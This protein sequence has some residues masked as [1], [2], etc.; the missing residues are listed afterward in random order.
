MPGETSILI[1]MQLC[2]LYK[3]RKT[4]NISLPFRTTSSTWMNNKRSICLSISFKRGLHFSKTKILFAFLIFCP[5]FFKMSKWYTDS[6]YALEKI[7]LTWKRE[8]DLKY[9]NIFP[10]CHIQL[11]VKVH[12]YREKVKNTVSHIF[13]TES[14]DTVYNLPTVKSEVGLKSI[15]MNV[16]SSLPKKPGRL[17]D[18]SKNLEHSFATQWGMLTHS[19][20]L[21]LKVLHSY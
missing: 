15:H 8:D 16:E 17:N 14:W 6:K 18:G 1:N 10:S 20:L 4:T 5:C 9:C 11:L 19:I 7:Y 21:H 12:T 2:T 13:C 3:I